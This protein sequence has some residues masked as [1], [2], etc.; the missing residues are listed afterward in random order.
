MTTPDLMDLPEQA[1][2]AFER[3]SG[4]Q[5]VVHDLAGNLGV[6]ILPER[7][8]HR[9]PACLAVKARHSCAC[10]DFEITRLRQE[11]KNQPEGRYHRCH[12]G[13]T[14][15]V[16]PAFLQGRLAWILFAGQARGRGDFR[17]L[18]RDVRTTSDQASKTRACGPS[19]KSTPDA[20]WNRCGSSAHVCWNGSGG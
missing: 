16:V 3:Q 17:D 9:S 18:A 6:F 2:R 11:V 5:V 20:C 8:K 4:L 1:I 10:E 12:A 7:F 14:E 15:W 13:F 19:T